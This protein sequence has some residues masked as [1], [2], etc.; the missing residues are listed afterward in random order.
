MDT[1][2]YH[3]KCSTVG[4]ADLEG[5]LALLAASCALQAGFAVLLYVW[6]TDL[7]KLYPTALD[8]AQVMA[9]TSGVAAELVVAERALHLL[10]T[11]CI[12]LTEDINVLPQ[13]APWGHFGLRRPVGT[14][15]CVATAA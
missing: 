9:Y 10:V 1:S 5:L 8:I 15:I 2:I 6:R 7:T 14:P 11:R 12:F 4:S 3:D 13:I